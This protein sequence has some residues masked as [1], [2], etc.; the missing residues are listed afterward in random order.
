MVIPAPQWQVAPKCS[1]IVAKQHIKGENVVLKS[2]A[3]NALL[4]VF[5]MHFNRKG[6]RHASDLPEAPH[7]VEDVTSSS[8]SEISHIRSYY[9][10]PERVEGV[11]RLALPESLRNR[12]RKGRVPKTQG[13]KK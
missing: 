11:I 13:K 9:K 4:R 7:K 1:A 6:K 10:N 3:F 8:P 12:G 2:I 5:S